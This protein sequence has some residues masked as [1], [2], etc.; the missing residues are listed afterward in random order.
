MSLVGVDIGSTNCKA[1]LFQAD[2]TQLASASREYAEV[3]PGPNMIE[4]PAE[5]VW[6]AVCEV[7]NRVGNEAKNDPIQ[8]VCFSA[9]GEA[10]TPVNRDGKFLHNTIVS[11][12]NRA[13][14]QMQQLL[15]KINARRIFE[16]T[17]MP[18]HPSLTLG[19]VMWLRENMPQVHEQTWK[20]L[21]WP[22]TAAMKL[23]LE[24]RMDWT[25]A[26][27]SMAFNVVGKEFSSEILEAANLNASMF[28]TPIASGEVVGSIG[29]GGH[30]ESGLPAGC[31]VVA[32]GHDQPMTALGAGVI[33][34]G[35][36]V[37]GMGTVE[38]I[39][40]AFRQPVL[41]EAMREHNY[42]CYP[43]VC[44]GL[45]ASLAYNYTCGAALRWFRD[46]LGHAAQAQATAEGLDVYDVLTADLP[47]DPTGLLFVPYMAGSG[48]P[49]LDPHAKGI[50]VGLT[51]G[52]DQKDLV[53]GMLEGIC[54]ELAL[55]IEALDEAGVKIERLRCTGGGS[56]SRQ[57]MQ[58]KADITGREC[59]A[60]DVSEGGCL[61]AAMLAGVQA[62]VYSSVEEAV[63]LLVHEKES[64]EPD[65][66]AHARY[67]EH[68]ERYKEVWPTLRDVVHRMGT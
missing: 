48:T 28:A 2:G 67:R 61:A 47:Q 66:A 68:F 10:F 38:C 43:H 23:G 31:L 20:Y 33:H 37:D 64:F 6:A 22:D 21:T 65:M 41:T 18:A 40:V 14:P 55:N 36:A 51:L 16:I 45:Y 29:P 32:G 25:E 56:R 42:C 13:V 3:Y 24:P 44:N 19:K 5:T 26:G 34:E 57:W 30:A 1:I 35:M 59:V 54:Y 39:T 4:L 11:A 17:G 12:D 52:C 62:G 46:N 63:G 7:L 8:G 50:L 27:R 49:Y 60:L 15:E 58:L 9:I 53:K